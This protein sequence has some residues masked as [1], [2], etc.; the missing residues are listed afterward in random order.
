MKAAVETGYLVKPPTV[1]VKLPRVVH[2]EMR[3]LTAQQVNALAHAMPEPYPTMVYV[4]AYGGIRWGEMAALRRSRC[5]LLRSR[6]RIVESLADVEG[7]APLRAD[8]DLRGAGRSSAHL[9]TCPARRASRKP[10][11]RR[12]K[13]AG[14][15]GPERISITELKLSQARHE[16]KRARH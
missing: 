11:S 12:P 6:I 14:V 15:H 9:P 5:D 2:R 10:C 8:Q 3:F 16:S 4:L 1:G 13:R 7:S